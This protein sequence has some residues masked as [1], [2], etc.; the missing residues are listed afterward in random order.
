MVNMPGLPDLSLDRILLIWIITIFVLRVVVQGERF[1]GPYWGDLFLFLHTL[2]ILVQ[3]Q[4]IGSSHHFHEWVL[5]MFTPMMGFIYGKYT[6]KKDR[7][8]RNLLVFLFLLSI[9]YS[10]MS[11]AQHHSIDPLLWPKTILDKSKGLW[12][13]GRSRGPVLHPPMFGQLIALLLMVNLFFLAKARTVFMRFVYGA[14]FAG[15]MLGSLYTYTRGPWVALIAGFGFMAFFSK[16]FR[17]ILLILAVI[18]FM[19]G[20]LGVAQM[21]NSEF[22]Q[23]R[24]ENTNTIENRLGFLANTFRMTRDNPLFGIGYFQWMEEVGYYNQTTTIPLYGLVRKK[25]SAHV[26]I[27]DIYLGRLAEE[28]I[29][30]V[31]L[32]WAF[33]LVIFRAFVR[34][35]RANVWSKWFDRDIM[36]L[37]GAILFTY[38]VGGMV[39][40]YRYFDLINVLFYLF[41]GIIYGY[42]PKANSNP[43]A[44][45]IAKSGESLA[46]RKSS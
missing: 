31:T 23:E 3:M 28:G 20:L 21:A 37:I 10:L 6:I 38:M 18:G 12:H 9:Y 4:F 5:S 17:G 8:L 32:Q 46:L 36:V 34:K 45:P 1:Q 43:T 42:N 15:S 2:Y 33:Y 24:L 39:I 26:P 25:T 29:L 44:G 19:A 35:F 13:T 30:G 41:A 27:H 11:I 14:C 40:D 22:L 7:E 16:S